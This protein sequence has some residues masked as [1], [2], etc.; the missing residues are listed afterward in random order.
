VYS[1]G[2]VNVTEASVWS[3]E[4]HTGQDLKRQSQTFSAA[5]KSFKP[6]AATSL[7]CYLE[8]GWISAM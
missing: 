5:V 8:G 4:S 3:V 2:Y 7:G 6:G 1:I